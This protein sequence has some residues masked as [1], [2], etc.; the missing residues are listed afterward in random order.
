MGRRVAVAGVAALVAGAVL[1][2]PSVRA[3][4]GGGACSQPYPA[5]FVQEFDPAGAPEPGGPQLGVSLDHRLL[6]ESPDHFFDTD[7][8]GVED[9]AS[10]D[11]PT[12]VLTRGDGELRLQLPTGLTS[13][14]VHGSSVNLGSPVGDLDGDGRPEF[15]VY[16][17]GGVHRN[18]LVLGTT[19]PGTHPVD[20]VAVDNSVVGV[21]GVGDQDGD[22]VD[23]A[24][25]F[26]TAAT[27]YGDGPVQI[28]RGLDLVA[29]GAGG[30][31]ADVP[32]PLRMVDHWVTGVLD[33]GA[34]APVLAASSP[35]SDAEQVFVYLPQGTVELA[36]PPTAGA[37][38]ASGDV[39]ASR[40]GDDRIIV[41][42]QGWR[43]GGRS[44]MW[45]LDAPCE[46]F[47]AEAGSPSGTAPPAVPAAPASG[48]AS[49]T[50]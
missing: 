43:N 10:W 35:F 19:A 47:V 17:D 50:G 34:D 32:A 21:G 23:D 27:E 2:G 44:V 11:G 25:A 29:P 40:Y 5:W 14:Q 30:I 4:D 49:Y 7:L 46:P 13:A 31:L 1:I 45:N 15:E 36:V 38:G 24:M 37:Y 28:L 33:L 6:G 12:L 42:E 18:Y 41:L 26:G 3:Q 8:D 20:E 9:V 39:H 16:V 48:A 22:G